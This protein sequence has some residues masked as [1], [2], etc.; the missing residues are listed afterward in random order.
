MADSNGNSPHPLIDELIKRPY[1]FDFFLAV[2]LIES[3]RPDLPRV[4]FSF[5]PSEDPVRFWQK[6]SL[7]FAPAALDSVWANPSDSVPRMAVTFFGLFG[8]NAPM[9]PH[10][11][12]YVLERELH[13][14]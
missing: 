3:R 6:P 1:A 12:E 10:I 2:R 5:G 7:R 11:T 4:G 8:P 14:K 9:P 13:H